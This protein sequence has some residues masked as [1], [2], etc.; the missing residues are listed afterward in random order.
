MRKTLVVRCWLCLL[1]TD[2]RLH[3]QEY[4]AVRRFLRKRQSS[5][6]TPLHSPGALSEAMDLA[7]VFYFRRLSPLHRALCHT[8]LLRDDGWAAELVVG[9]QLLPA[10]S[11]AWVEVDGAP[12]HERAGAL[13]TYQVLDRC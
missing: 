7:S 2:M 11:Y 5:R 12:I 1:L 6:R 13:D 9:I 8:M 10:E 4:P 3:V